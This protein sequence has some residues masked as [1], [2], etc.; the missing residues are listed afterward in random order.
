MKK[1]ELLREEDLVF[2]RPGNGIDP[3]KEAFLVGRRLNRDVDTDHEL[4]WSDLD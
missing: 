4:E 3:D 1:G 2:K